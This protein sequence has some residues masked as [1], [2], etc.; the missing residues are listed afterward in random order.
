MT[1]L[2][3]LSQL[4]NHQ[5]F[6]MEVTL[7]EIMAMAGAYDSVVGLGTML[8]NRRSWVQFPMM[9]LNCF[10][11]RIPS[12]GTMALGLTQPLTEMSTSNLP[13]E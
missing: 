6:S 1:L 5:Q 7:A 13:G 10:N 4:S 8:Q 9:S 12:S 2:I 3:K 11:L